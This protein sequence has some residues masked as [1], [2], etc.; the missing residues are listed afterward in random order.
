MT[1]ANA[2]KLHKPKAFRRKAINCALLVLMLWG[3]TTAAA[4]LALLYRQPEWAKYALCW[5]I[6]LVP[7]MAVHKIIELRH[8]WQNV[9]QDE[10]SNFYCLSPLVASGL[11]ALLAAITVS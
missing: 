8:I 11:I 4:L 1:N 3:L 2:I 10:W 7:G 9:Q 5:Q 6:V